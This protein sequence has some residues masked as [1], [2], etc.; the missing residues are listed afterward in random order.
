MLV[1]NASGHPIKQGGIEVVGEAQIPNVDL[2]DP[3]AVAS[4]A[5]DIADAAEP[6]VSGGVP[7]ALPGMSVLAAHVLACIHGLVGHWPDIVWS[8]R[9]DGRFVWSDEFRAD[10]HDVRTDQRTR[11]R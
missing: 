10:L 8:C 5:Q 9:I 4:V 1:F 3:Q 6:H 2:T 11:R 7:I